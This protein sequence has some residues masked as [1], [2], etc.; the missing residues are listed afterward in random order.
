MALP[1]IWLADVLRGA[2]LKVA[3]QPGW[4]TRGSSNF[5]PAKGVICH[6]TAGAKTGIMP[7]LK[8]VTQR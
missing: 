3:E 7:S 2:G 6:H 5:G 4:E 1:L 8:V